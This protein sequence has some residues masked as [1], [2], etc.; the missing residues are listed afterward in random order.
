MAI[1]K[2]GTAPAGRKSVK[3][4][5]DELTEKIK[6][7]VK[8]AL[9]EQAEAKAEGEEGAEV[10]TA[11][12]DPADI[13]GLIEEA[14]SVVAEKRKSRKDAGEELGDVTAEEVMEAV[15]ELLDATGGEAK[16]D[17]GIEE[18]VKEDDGVTDEAKGRKAAT[19]KIKACVKEALDEQAEAEGEEGTEDAV[20]EVAPADISGLIEDAMAVVAE[21]RKSRKE[22]GED[23]GDVTAEEVMEAVGEIIDATEGEAK[24]DDGVEE[25]VKEDEEVTDEAK[26]RKAATRKHQTKSARKSAASPVQRKYSSIYMSRTT[27]TSTAKKSIPPAVQLARAI[28]CLDVFGKH[29]P[30][31]ASFYAQRKYD[32]ADMAREFKAL[33]ATNPAAGGYLIPEIYLDQI[34]E[35]LYSKTVI[36]ELGAQKVPMANGNLN[37][38]K[39]TGG[40]RATWGGEARKIAKTQLTYGNIRLSAKR[41]EAI[42]PQT[43]ELLMSTNYSADQLFAN[44]LTRRM[45]LGL[46]FGA[47]FGKGGEFQPL[48]VFTDKEVE[49]VDAK[50]LSNEDLADSNGKITADFPVFVRSKVLAKNVDDNK[51]G[52]A[53]N[54][55]LVGEQMGLETYTTLDGSWVDEEG[56]QHNAFEENLAATR[57]LMYVDIAARHKESF[58]HIKNIKAF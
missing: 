51:L 13:S 55:L 6:A 27:P 30:D 21:K 38:P 22:A 9:D 33:S 42:V 28:K 10:A 5:A 41:L 17:D 40:A 8:E 34:I 16:E 54:Y 26:G 31:A 48:G 52:W 1:P 49:H 53:F 47:M 2:K 11:E 39:M 57:A 50:T 35:L 43:R 14:M 45:E 12:V 20:A 32:D 36:F 19:E 4:E 56:N 44:D 7:C 18:E 29:D 37:I 23:L 25:E 24:E 15:G 46:D 3:M 58:L